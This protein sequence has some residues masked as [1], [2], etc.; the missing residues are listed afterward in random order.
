M[1]IK[2]NENEI[3]DDLQ[4]NGMKIIRNPKWFSYG[5]DAV[6]LS[7]YCNFKKNSTVL[8]IG[9]GTG[10]I[11]ILINAKNT[12]NKIYGFEVQKEV[13]D[14][15]S[16]SIK[17][18]DIEDKVTI[19]NDDINNYQNYFSN[20]SLDAI[21][22]NPPYKIN[23]TGLKN[24]LTQKSISRHEILCTLDDIVRI[25]SKLLKQLGNL[26]LVH[27]P[28]RLVDIFCTL[29]KYNIE[30][31]QIRF[32][33]SHVGDKPN[34]VLIKATKCGGKELLYDK[35]LYIYKNDNTYTED[36]LKIYDN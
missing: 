31:K 34:L 5:M 32:V 15:A 25:S 3:I 14:M 17:L 6:L 20:S 29:R 1:K 18:N 28:D 36:L 26:Y 9:T 24:E 4:C 12:L 35:P 33:H 7:N 10:I 11:P 23:N 2:L 8:D 13:A 21:V 30:P 22:S 19:I 16:R 27:R